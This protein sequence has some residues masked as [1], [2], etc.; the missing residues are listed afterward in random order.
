MFETRFLTVLE[1]PKEKLRFVV[2]LMTYLLVLKA[3]FGVR[4]GPDLNET[5]HPESSVFG[6]MV[7]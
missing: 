6:E 7:N 4:Y 5:I 2:Y 1:K 3:I